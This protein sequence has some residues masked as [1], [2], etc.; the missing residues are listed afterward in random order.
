MAVTI[1]LYDINELAAS[2]WAIKNCPSFRG[3]LIYDNNDPFAYLDLDEREWLISYEFEFEDEQEAMLFQL[4]W[5][6]QT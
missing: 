4:R 1:T 2:E 3:W 6:G 5:Q